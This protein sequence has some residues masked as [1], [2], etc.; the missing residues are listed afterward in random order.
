MNDVRVDDIEARLSLE[1]AQVGTP[2]G[3]KAVEADD[4]SA[5]RE[6]RIAQVGSEEPRS[7][8]NQDE[9]VFPVFHVFIPWS[10]RRARE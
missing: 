10:A 8:C 1:V 9:P 7:A 2:P 5:F 4:V 3:P 6:E